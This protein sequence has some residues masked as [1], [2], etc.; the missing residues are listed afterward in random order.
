LCFFGFRFSGSVL[1]PVHFGLRVRLRFWTSGTRKDQKNRTDKGIEPCS[2]V[3]PTNRLAQAAQA[4][5]SNIYASRT[6]DVYRVQPP[7]SI[8]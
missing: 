7:H 3:T 8:L 2:P 6:L 1:K 4:T 5:R